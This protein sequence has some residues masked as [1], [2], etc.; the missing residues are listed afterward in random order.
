MAPI[1]FY[2]W[3]HDGRSEPEMIYAVWGKQVWVCSVY[4]GL[5]WRRSMFYKSAKLVRQDL[6]LTYMG[7]L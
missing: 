2:A 5:D 7:S 6:S 4:N 3:C 1:S